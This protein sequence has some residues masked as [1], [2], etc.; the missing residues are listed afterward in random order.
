MN[1]TAPLTNPSPYASAKDD[2]TNDRSE[3]KLVSLELSE[4]EDQHE[5]QESAQSY[6]SGCKFLVIMVGLALSCIL[7]ALVG[8][9]GK[10][11][12]YPYPIHKLTFH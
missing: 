12:G 5:E 2:T 7:V 1:D 6:P 10:I 8:P 9:S 4:S 3:T 11:F